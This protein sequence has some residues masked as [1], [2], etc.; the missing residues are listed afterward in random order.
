LEGGY[1]WRVGDYRIRYRIDEENK[2]VIL[3]D[4]GSRRSIYD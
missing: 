4:F 2:T 1:L 3:L